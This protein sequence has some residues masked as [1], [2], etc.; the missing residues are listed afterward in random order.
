VPLVL[1][2]AVALEKVGVPLT[3]RFAA[4][5]T[6]PPLAWNMNPAKPMMMQPDPTVTLPPP[7]AKQCAPVVATL[8]MKLTFWTVALPPPFEATRLVADR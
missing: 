1:A 5:V 3:V 8:V 6:V 2:K 4:N 7:P